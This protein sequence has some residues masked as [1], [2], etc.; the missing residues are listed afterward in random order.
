MVLDTHENYAAYP[1]LTLEDRYL[2]DLDMLLLG[3]FSPLE[4]FL[5]E[6]DYV[7]VVERCRLANGA[8]WSMP[9][10]LPV[11][12]VD[13]ERLKEA[14]NILLKDKT[15]LPIAVLEVG[16]AVGS[17]YKPDL[18]KECVNVYGTEDT[19][20]P[21]VK[22]VLELGDCYYY[23]GRVVKVRNVV[24]Y[25]FVENR[26]SAAGSRAMIAEKGWKVV[27]GFQTRNPMHRSHFE[28]T[29]FAVKEAGEE[30]KLLLTPV[31]GVTQL[32]DVNYHVRVRCYQKLMPYYAK[33]GVEAEL[34]LLTVSMRMA[35]LREELCHA[36]IKKNYG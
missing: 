25:D 27:V 21:Y 10:V 36:Q 7:S 18:L 5:G 35:E 31:V 34:V 24:H 15:G 3:G 12:R 33:E 22:I 32:C 13:H 8:L 28:L 29:K 6:E 19:N 30:A 16:G 9:I 4:G 17:K 20:H 2:C 1:S 11:S 14:V 26:M 23:G